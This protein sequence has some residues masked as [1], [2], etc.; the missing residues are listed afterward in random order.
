MHHPMAVGAEEHEIGDL[1]RLARPEKGNR[2]DVV[3]FDKIAPS[4]A[5]YLREIKATRLTEKPPVVF[6]EAGLLAFDQASAPLAAAMKPRDQAAFLRLC[7]L[8]LLR[9]GRGISSVNVW[10]GQP[11][12]NALGEFAKLLR[13][14]SEALPKY[15]LEL[16]SPRQLLPSSVGVDWVVR[17]EV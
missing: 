14:V 3:A 10:A 12:S 8:G 1:R 15:G 13:L 17:A 11:C 7:D 5:I 4:R 6:P 16:V 2:P 9:L